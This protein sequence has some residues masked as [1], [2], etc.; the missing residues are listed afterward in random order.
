VETLWDPNRE[1]VELIGE[2]GS[3]AVANLAHSRHRP[4]DEAVAAQQAGGVNSAVAAREGRPAVW[5]AGCGQP[6]G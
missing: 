3:A 2:A 6:V 5:G 1:T 4:A